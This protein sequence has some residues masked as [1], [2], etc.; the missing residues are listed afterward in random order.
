[1]PAKGN[2]KVAFYFQSEFYFTN[3]MLFPSYITL[4]QKEENITEKFF[5]LNC[6]TN[7]KAS[8]KHMLQYNTKRKSENS[9]SP[10]K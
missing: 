3:T 8:L 2:N 9:Q 7:Q 6:V 4:P 5:F 10:L 1:M